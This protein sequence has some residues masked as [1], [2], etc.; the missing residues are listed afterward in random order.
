MENGWL[1]GCFEDDFLGLVLGEVSR[2]E[3]LLCI[4]EIICLLKSVRS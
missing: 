1:G 4:C 3:L 2:D